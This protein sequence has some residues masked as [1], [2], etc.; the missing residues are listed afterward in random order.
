MLTYMKPDIITD[1]RCTCLLQSLEAIYHQFN[2]PVYVE[3][4]PLQFLYK[5]PDIRDREIAGFI[6]ASLAYGQVLQINRAV[7]TALS[8]MHWQPYEYVV[9]RN[10]KDITHNFSSFRY[11]FAQPEHMTHLILGIKQVLTEFS[12]L[13]NCFLSGY[14]KTDTSIING[15]IF[16]IKQISRDH[17]P[18]HLCIDPTLKSACKRNNL[19]LR[20]MVRQDA[21]D[22]GGWNSVCPSKLLIPLDIHMHRIGTFMGF[23]NRRS[24]DLKTAVEITDGFKKIIPRDPVKYD[25]SLTRYGIRKDMDILQLKECLT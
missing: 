14:S 13:E 21:V 23:T 2:L 5:F 11:R 18:G 19:F 15:L 4:D 8:T 20:W 12:T 7:E 22:P 1:N 16:L 17:N 10:N 25:F 3:P 6:A 24:A 9:G